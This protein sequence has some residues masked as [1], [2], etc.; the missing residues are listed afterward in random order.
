MRALRVIAVLV[1]CATVLSACGEA[2]RSAD[3]A[4]AVKT[5]RAYLEALA[6]RDTKTL[7]RVNLEIAAR[8]SGRRCRSRMRRVTFSAAR[9]LKT[10]DSLRARDA[11]RFVRVDARVTREAEGQDLFGVP[12]TLWLAQRRGAWRVVKAGK[13]YAQARGFVEGRAQDESRP[14]VQADL[15]Q[16][17]SRG[18]AGPPCTKTVTRR[19][20]ARDD[21]QQFPGQ[22]AR[23]RPRRAFDFA[24]IA[25]RRDPRG[26]VCIQVQM[27][28]RV[29]TGTI[30]DLRV[31]QTLSQEEKA[32]DADRLFGGGDAW[33]ANAGQTTFHAAPG[34]TVEVDG[35]AII[36]RLRPGALFVERKFTIRVEARSG[37]PGEPLLRRPLGAY[38]RVEIRRG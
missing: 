15:A 28:D 13:L 12:A 30:V 24:S 1:A 19:R 36:F 23:Q 3:H 32:L 31:V 34:N 18:K 35:H 16:P 11:G 17:P 38:D 27:V 20:D 25:V 5:A 7:C 9:R 22:R 26:L 29:R 6:A 14:L 21:V 4:G 37:Q 33:I 8:D 2:D 10:V